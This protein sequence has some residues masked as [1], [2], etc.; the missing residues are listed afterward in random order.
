VLDKD[1]EGTIGVVLRLVTVANGEAVEFVGNWEAFGI[2]RVAVSV[3]PA[4]AVE[5]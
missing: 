5:P 2:I 1:I 3:W 4:L